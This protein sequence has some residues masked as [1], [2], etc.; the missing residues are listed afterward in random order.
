M[1]WAVMAINATADGAFPDRGPEPT[2]EN[3]G[4]LASTVRA[5]KADLGIAHDGDGDRMVAV[6][7][8]GRFVGGDGLLALF[9]RQEVRRGLV[10][11]VDAPMV[12]EDLL[13]SAEVW[14]TRVRDVYV[15]AR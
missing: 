3:L 1:G 6:D 15:P 14:R 13:P 2:E 10:V 11:P 12:L 7:R 5:G 4:I 9:A 8:E